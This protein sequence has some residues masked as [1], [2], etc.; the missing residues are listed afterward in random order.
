[1]KAIKTK[2][3]KFVLEVEIFFLITAVII[4]IEKEN[5]KQ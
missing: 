4:A 5:M 1:M 2:T 3:T